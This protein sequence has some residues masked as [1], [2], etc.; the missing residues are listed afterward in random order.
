[1]TISI[2]HKFQSAKSDGGDASL[3][4]PSNWNDE[5]DLTMAA[6]RL[7]G[8]SSGTAGAAQE[9]PLGTGL[10]F[11]AGALEADYPG[12]ATGIHAATEKTDLVDNDE[13]AGTDSA[14][15]FGLI[16]ATGQGLL[17]Y[18]GVNAKLDFF[19]DCIPSW[20]SNTSIA[21]TTGFGFFGGKKYTLPAYTKSLNAQ[22]A[23]GNNQG[24]MDT[25]PM[26]ASKTYFVFAIRNIASGVC[27]YLASLSLTPAVPGGYELGGRIGILITN[28]STQIIRFVQRG[29]KINFAPVLWF[30]TN[31]DIAPG[32]AIPVFSPIGVSVDMAMLVTVSASGTSV[33]AFAAVSDADAMSATL[34]DTPS[35]VTVRARTGSGDNIDQSQAAGFARS[36][37]AGQIMRYVDHSSTGGTTFMYSQGWI[38]YSCKRLFA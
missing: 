12:M 28:A 21:F 34:T 31:V 30:S 17:K 15:S 32:L 25:G 19:T 11:N 35:G 13:F 36:N 20:V 33:D 29:N 5:H 10:K 1:M 14:N 24:F 37:T 6:S 4:R 18:L 7:F 26:Q 9:I 16:K 38:D 22:W 23:S 2:K 8:R 3:V 27:D